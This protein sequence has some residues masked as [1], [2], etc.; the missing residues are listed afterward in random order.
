[1][2]RI[3]VHVVSGAPRSGKSALITRLCAQRADWLGLVNSVPDAAGS[4]LASVA[5]G[6]PCCTGKIV[7]QITLAR[8]LR[9]TRA[10]RAFVELSDPGHAASLERAL[11]EAPLGLSIVCARSIFQP[12]DAE[13][14]AADLEE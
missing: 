5:A 12:R 7:L 14:S 6:C 8:A 3:P 4:N 11:G 10:T 2:T 13:L 1:M 9:Q